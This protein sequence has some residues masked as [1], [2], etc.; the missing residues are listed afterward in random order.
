MRNKGT[1]IIL[2]LVAAAICS[3]CFAADHVR[4]LR[5]YKVFSSSLDKLLLDT[6]HVYI[7]I[8]HESDG[9][10]LTGFRLGCMGHR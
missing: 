6:R 3:S 1:I 7:Q 2:M 9:F 8:G 5:T 4:V 10:Y